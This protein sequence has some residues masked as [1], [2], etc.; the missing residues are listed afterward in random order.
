MIRKRGMDLEKKSLKNNMIL[1]TYAAV[2][3]LVL[4]N[5]REIL[6]GIGKLLS[7]LNSFFIGVAIA[8]VLR[9]PSEKFCALYKKCRVGDKAA[10]ILGIVSSYLL[11]V[12]L[13]GA[14]IGVVIPQLVK[15]IQML[16]LSLPGY[17]GEIQETINFLTD[18]L[19]IETADISEFFQSLQLSAGRIG[20]IIDKAVPHI[21]EGTMNAISG[22][23]TFFVGVA[24]SAYLMSG[25][26]RILNQLSRMGKAV[27]PERVYVSFRHIG[28]V[29]LESFDNYV[30]GQ[31]TEATILGCLCFIGMSILRL[32]YAGM[33]S[34]IVALTALIP[35][36]GAYIGG[37]VAV[38]LLMM[39]S[40]KKAVIFLIFLVIL[41][42]VENNAIYPRVVGKKMGLPG[43]WILLAISVG[44]KV[45]GVLGMIVGVPVTTV[46]YTLL[47]EGVA[48]LEAK[49]RRE[50]EKKLNETDEK[51]R[52]GVDKPRGDMLSS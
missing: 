10:R 42:Q 13:F 6:G 34:V 16:V 40:L 45:G 8:F 38:I 52:E 24:F 50:D 15:N 48:E 31:I 39:V 41:Q 37:A 28:R 22:I 20:D 17:A 21:A 46:F 33:I 27:L 12:V 18:K 3:L 43:I 25:K 1:I 36:F 5:F 30:T 29:V 47:K 35:I 2:L 19:G 26:N 44:G 49:K 32:D 9:N 51:M 14:V 4:V 11:I 23:A 7:L